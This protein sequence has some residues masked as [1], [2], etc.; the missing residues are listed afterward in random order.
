MR[1]SCNFTGKL[2][3]DPKMF[4]GQGVNRVCFTLSVMRDYEDKE[5]N[6]YAD[7]F[8]FTAWRDTADYIMRHFHKGDMMRVDNARAKVRM[9]EDSNG[10]KRRKIEFEVDGACNV[11]RDKEED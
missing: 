7:F 11:F 4:E 8:D 2:V 6:V 10:N 3:S 1:N 5:G 9:Y